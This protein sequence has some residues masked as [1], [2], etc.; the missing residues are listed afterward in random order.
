ML[1]SLKTQLE[2]WLLPTLSKLVGVAD[3]IM[4]NRKLPDEEIQE[5][6]KL[7]VEYVQFYRKTYAHLSFAMPGP[8]TSWSA[9]RPPSP[10]RSQPPAR[11][12]PP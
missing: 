4:M 1:A 7:R 3:Y 11:R 12:P 10:P 5:G 6:N 8:T 9:S 2:S